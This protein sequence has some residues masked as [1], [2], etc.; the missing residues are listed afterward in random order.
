MREENA[1]MKNKWAYRTHSFCTNLPALITPWGKS[2][3][4]LACVFG[5]YYLLSNLHCFLLCVRALYV[6]EWPSQLKMMKWS[7]SKVNP[8][9]FIFLHI[10]AKVHGVVTKFFADDVKVY[11][12]IVKSDNCVILQKALDVISCWASD[13]QL[14]VSVEKCNMLHIGS[15]SVSYQYSM[16]HDV[17]SHETQCKNLGVVITVCLSRNILYVNVQLRLTG[18]QTASEMFCV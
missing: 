11:L 17:I 1:G 6:N 13:W 18:V 15:C 3:W 10:K 9:I 12:R 16:G 4:P 2:L 8:K 5:C 7:K 14:K